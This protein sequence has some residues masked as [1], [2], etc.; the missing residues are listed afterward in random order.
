MTE[1]AAEWKKRTN[2]RSND[3]QRLLPRHFRMMELAMQ[4]YSTKEIAQACDVHIATV[5]NVFNS[6]LFQEEV[7]KRRMDR[8]EK[9]EKEVERI[10]G[11]ALEYLQKHAM[12]AARKTVELVGSDNER[13]A[14]SSAKEI[15]D[16]V[17]SKERHTSVF[18]D[19]DAMRTLMDALRETRQVKEIVVEE[20]VKEGEDGS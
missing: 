10:E 15:L 13:I 16:R 2:Q 8:K 18:M 4:G 1:L 12:T 9:L 19:G 11:D 6:P 14:L 20:K 7:S 17:A 3:L 5:S